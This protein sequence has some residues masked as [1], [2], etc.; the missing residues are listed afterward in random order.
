MIYKLETGIPI[1]PRKYSTG[2][3][4]NSKY[5]F[6]QLKPGDS[7]FVPANAKEVQTIRTNA[8]QW[9]RKRGFAS[10]TRAANIGGIPGVR[11]WCIN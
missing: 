4:N 10:V 8:G 1:T 9:F 2:L 5:G 3:S 6:H 7:V 11:V